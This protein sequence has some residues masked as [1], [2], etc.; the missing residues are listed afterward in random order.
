MTAVTRRPETMWVCGVP[1][2]QLEFEPNWG[3]GL[4]WFGTKAPLGS[5]PAPPSSAWGRRLDGPSRGL[6]QAQG[7]VRERV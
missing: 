3:L 5:N 6:R 1:G 4:P 7:G 2:R